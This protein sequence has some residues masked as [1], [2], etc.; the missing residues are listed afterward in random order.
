MS[1]TAGTRLGAYQVL[2][3]IGAG[4]MGEVY[5][6]RD[7]KLNRDVA[8]KVLPDLFASDPDRLARFTREAQTLAALNHPNIAHIHGI[9]ESPGMRAIVME[10]VEGEDLS[11]QIARG[12]IPLPG[13][14]PIAKQI[15]DALEAAH[16]QGIVHRDLK[17]ANIKIRRD[18]TVKVLDFGLAKLSSY[19][20]G[21]APGF[22]AAHSPTFTAGT[23]MGVILG[24]AAYMSPEQARGKAVDKR[25]DIWAFGVVL[26]EMLTGRRMFDG[27]SV[28]ETLGLIFAREPDLAALP[29]ATPAIIRG[30]IARCL[31]KDPRQRLRDIGDARLQIDDA[32][33]GR[34]ETSGVS[35][36]A[37]AVIEPR[38]SR[39]TWL[40]LAVAVIVA[41][42]AGWFAR[43][44]APA[45][46]VRLSIAL[47]PGEQA[48]TAPAISP[49]GRLIAYAAGRTAGTSQLYLRALDD[50]TVHPVAGSAGA[51]YPFFSPDG[52]T[53]AFFASGK[54]RRASVGG[55]AA[56]DVAS[57]PTAWGGTWD[58]DGRIVYTTGLNSG[59]WR[60]SADGGIPEQLTKPDGAAAGYAHVF[61]QR[62]PGTQDLLFTFWGQTF[63]NALLSGKTGTWQEVTPQQKQGGAVAI[64]AA[65]GH[66]I[67]ND[68]ADGVVVAQW[69]PAA[70]GVVS[71]KTPVIQHV[72]WA[73]S[74]ERSW[75]DVSNTGT[76]VFVPGDPSNRHVA[77]VDRQGQDTQLPSDPNLIHQATLSHDGRRVVYGSM[78]SQWIADLTTG[79]RTRLI[80][81]VRSWHGAWLPGDERIVVSSNKDGDWDLFTI[82]SNGGEMTPL[83]RKPFAQHAQAVGPD[84]SI[85]YLERQ[86]ATGSDL[87]TLAPDG[88]TTPL[89][90]TRFNETAASI[91]PDGRFI[92]YVSDESG[93]NEVYAIPSSGKQS[94]VAI[95]IDGGTG[96]VWS[97]DGRELFYRAGDDLM[98]VQVRTSRDPG[99]GARDPATLVLGERKR[100]LDLSAYDSGYFHEFDVSTDG[101]RFL[102]IRTEPA[103]RPVRLDI[104]INWF[105]ELTTKV[106]SR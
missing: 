89:V 68:G 96:P 72:N 100:L 86:P 78:K 47:P 71:P 98:S 41:G 20:D 30:L 75:I 27:E 85:V 83:L 11:A 105:E 36:P 1:L 61:P 67:T 80:A 101:Q 42:A 65:S 102:L 48:T 24:T 21:A 70:T 50:F 34:G 76:A 49:D 53:I 31:V 37:P 29:A 95:S 64:Y 56:T 79:A 44:S 38:R 43:P 104:I 39:N 82:G 10:L 58:A 8:I 19:E 46:L 57:A 88:R 23:Q 73:L 60:V 51:Q 99:S 87:W 28:P 94:R 66:L 32:L 92:A 91:S 55:G 69:K 26:H 7:S 54:L 90:V 106:G 5:R 4:G 13:A 3:A 74:T 12:P 25:A 14:L 97:R 45:T 22:G 40:A 35:A 81:D 2:S 103:S 62:L 33:A 17:P 9:E 93:R 77:W 84:G 63:Y 16:E 6:A 18:G 59:L 15:A 52:R